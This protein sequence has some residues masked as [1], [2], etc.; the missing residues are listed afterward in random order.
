ML[1]ESQLAEYQHKG[2]LTI[3]GFYSP[4]TVT[5]I[6]DEI[7]NWA[8]QTRA[9]LGEND[10]RWY[11]EQNVPA[12]VSL[13]RKLDNPIYNRA[14]LR[15]L[16]VTPK[17]LSIAEQLIGKGLTVFFSQVF[18]KPA[19]YGGP[20]PV[21]QDNYYFGPE[22]EDRVLTVWMAI[23]NATLENGCLYYGDGSHHTGVHQHI[24]PPD[25]PFN[26]MVP[27]EIAAQYPMTPAPVS[28]GG[29]SLHHGST[30]HQSS[31]NRSEF[32]R[33]ALAMHFIP[34]DMPLVNPAL[35]YDLSV[36]VSF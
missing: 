13:F 6:I 9:E 30:F 35:E 11:L 3:N 12:G 28:A 10:Q 21:H 31:E 25:E 27:A 18:M 33:R 17:L 19:R 34:Q 20:K 16:I 14:I 5:L 32:P 15:Q 7:N 2:H 22:D 36:V 24:A 29:I 4:Q 1:Y 8:D 23:D 26:L